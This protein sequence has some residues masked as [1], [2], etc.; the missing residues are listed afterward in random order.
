MGTGSG[1]CL[2][3][4]LLLLPQ[5]GVEMKLVGSRC[6]HSTHWRAWAELL[7]PLAPMDWK[8]KAPT[9]ISSQQLPVLNSMWMCE[10]CHLSQVSP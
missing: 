10:V 8:R 2:V 5:W 6:G 7:V 4:Q 3:L 1:A 9:A